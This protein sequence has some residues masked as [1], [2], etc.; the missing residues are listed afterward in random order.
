M[1]RVSKR[2][3]L[4]SSVAIGA[5]M[6]AGC[7]G[8]SDTTGISY[9]VPIDNSV[10]LMEISGIQ[11]Q[12]EHYGD[13]YELELQ[14][15]SST[16][17]SISA[18]AAGEVD[19][20]EITA[21]HFGSAVLNEPVQ[22]GVMAIANDFYDAHPDY[23]GNTAYAPSNSGIE[24]IEDLEGARLGVPSIG[25]ELHATFVKALNDV[26]LEED[27]A[28]FVEQP[29]PTLIEGMEEDMLDAAIL[30]ALFAVNAREKEFNE[31]FSTQDLE[32]RA[33]PYGFVITGQN[34]LDENESAIEAWVQDYT[35]TLDYINENRSE[36]ISLASDHFDMPEEQLEAY[37]LTEQ[38]YYRS[39]PELDA[40]GI[41]TS[42]DDFADMGFLE[43]SFNVADYVTN[44]YI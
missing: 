28:E 19:I 23:Y 37:W 15:E 20:A 27:D 30:P 5:G 33:I 43:E 16:P 7:L 36:A 13:E 2:D 24:E 12:L 18:L 26:G 32:E 44:E 9:S 10:S 38:D 39:E 8:N 25:T 6:V 41:Q 34:R 17:D 29:M 1:T 3:F 21:I 31:I 11:D 35:T 14:Q 22:G 4:K 42:I 40:E